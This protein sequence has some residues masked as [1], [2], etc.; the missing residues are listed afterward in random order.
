VE[1]GKTGPVDFDLE[2]VA[3]ATAKSCAIESGAGEEET[4][5]GIQTIAPGEFF[6]GRQTGPVGIYFENS[7]EIGAAAVQRRAVEGGA[8]QNDVALREPSIRAAEIGEDAE[9]GPIRIDLENRAVI[10]CSTGSR[11]SV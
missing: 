8:V 5:S 2:D 7:A 1:H 10:E 11:D 4:G 3:Q 6:N 9:P